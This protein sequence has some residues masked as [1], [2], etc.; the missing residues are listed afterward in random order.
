MLK[1]SGSFT[2]FLSLWLL[3]SAFITPEPFSGQATIYAATWNSEDRSYSIWRFIDPANPE[4][5]YNIPSTPDSLVVDRFSEYEFQLF[6]QHV[7]NSAPSGAEFAH[8]VSGNQ[9][10]ENLWQLDRHN[11]LVLMFDTFCGEWVFEC[12][13]HYELFKLNLEN[14]D[15]P[16]RTSLFRF[17]MHDPKLESRCSTSIRTPTLVLDPV[18]N[19]AVISVKLYDRYCAR[20]KSYLVLVDFEETPIILSEISDGFSPAW[21]LDGRQIAYY[22][23]IECESRDCPASIQ[24]YDLNE[25][26][27]VLVRIDEPLAEIL[28]C[29]RIDLAI[30]WLDNTTLLIQS[31]RLLTAD[32]EHYFI[33]YDLASGR[34]VELSRG[35]GLALLAARANL[36]PTPFDF[37]LPD[38]E[39]LISAVGMP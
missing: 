20:F 27:S 6:E 28:C 9:G 29:T 16:L 31:S 35:E 14:P 1:K 21:S 18:N 36:Q 34:E 4:L 2:L 7:T 24:R 5:V 25:R 26:R 23:W 17:D 15:A 38:N 11:L 22:E 33:Q 37:Q 39:T 8:V 3:L 30:N 10:I 32:Q 19:R 13:G 12:Y